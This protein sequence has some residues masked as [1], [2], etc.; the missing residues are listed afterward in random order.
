MR[1]DDLSHDRGLIPASGCSAP[2]RESQRSR[3]AFLFVRPSWSLRLIMSRVST[4]DALPGAAAAITIECAWSG[5]LENGTTSKAVVLPW[6]SKTSTVLGG[7]PGYP[8][9]RTAQPPLK[10]SAVVVRHSVSLYIT[11]LIA[12]R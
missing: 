12:P 8:S 7:W 10:G 9:R 11:Q 6:E 5:W 1:R 2:Y 4:L 3:A